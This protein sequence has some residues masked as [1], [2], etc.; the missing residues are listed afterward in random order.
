ML[1]FEILRI[2]YVMARHISLTKGRK[3]LLEMTAIIAHLANF[4]GERAFAHAD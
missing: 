2:W 3:S 1:D 4:M